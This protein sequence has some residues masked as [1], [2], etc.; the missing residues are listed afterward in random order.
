MQFYI[1]VIAR[2]KFVYTKCAFTHYVC[3][4]HS[5]HAGMKMPKIHSFSEVS[6]F[7]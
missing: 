5:V 6:A 1:Q 7:Q 2:N 3:E 4:V